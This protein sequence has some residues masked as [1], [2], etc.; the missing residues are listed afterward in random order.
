MVAK[1][2]KN[3]D[4]LNRSAERLAHVFLSTLANM[5]N[6]AGVYLTTLR[7]DFLVRQHRR[8]TIAAL[9]ALDERM[10]RDVG[11]AHTNISA[12]VNAPNNRDPRLHIPDP[13]LPI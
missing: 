1:S 5:R 9:E 8:R 13:G 11:L 2:I 3:T 4:V 10:L 12:F 6:R 7:K